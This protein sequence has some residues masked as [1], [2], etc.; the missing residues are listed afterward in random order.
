MAAAVAWPFGEHSST[1]RLAVE[2]VDVEWLKIDFSA[3]QYSTAGHILSRCAVYRRQ[4]AFIVFCQTY[5]GGF[6]SACPSVVPTQAQPRITLLSQQTTLQRQR[7]TGN[8]LQILSAVVIQQLGSGIGRVQRAHQSLVG[9]CYSWLVGGA[10]SLLEAVG[11][12]RDRYITEL[13]RKG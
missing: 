1:Q 9:G 12:G 8:D 7:Q 13:M 6:S 3:T 10:F 2:I 11:G 5:E 4:P